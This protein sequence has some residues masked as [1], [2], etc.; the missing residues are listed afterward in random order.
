MLPDYPPHIIS[1]LQET[2]HCSKGIGPGY[3]PEYDL[4][5]GCGLILIASISVDVTHCMV[6]APLG[7]FVGFLPQ[8]PP[9]VSWGKSRSFKTIQLPGSDCTTRPK[10][11]SM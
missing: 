2:P 11:A 4:S 1:A 10:A 6:V 7:G 9:D 3:R 5:H 8:V